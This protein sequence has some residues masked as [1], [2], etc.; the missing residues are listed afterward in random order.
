MKTLARVKQI[1]LNRAREYT[2][3]IAIISR[4]PCGGVSDP[5]D[6]CVVRH[7]GR[8]ASYIAHYI[9]LHVYIYIYIYKRAASDEIRK[10]YPSAF[11][12][13]VVSVKPVQMVVV[14]HRS[15]LMKTNFA[16]QVGMTRRL[17]DYGWRL[18]L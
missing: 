16:S 12:G 8:E 1:A 2:S 18:G 13:A 4:R 14:K 6:L 3:F 5:F 10:Q 15:E 11:S 9:I 17:V 7:R